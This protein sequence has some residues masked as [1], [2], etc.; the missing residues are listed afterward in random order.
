MFQVLLP[1]DSDVLVVHKRFSIRSDKWGAVLVPELREDV[2]AWAI[3][4]RIE[5]SV[6]DNQEPKNLLFDN[7]DHA[8]MFKLR[9]A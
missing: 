4:N 9:W 7:R 8:I 3:E 5:I 2:V 6:Q 1:E